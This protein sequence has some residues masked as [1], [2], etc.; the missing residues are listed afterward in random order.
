MKLL[1]AIRCF[2]FGVAT[3]A[4]VSAATPAAPNLVVFLV[5]DM[6]VMD[7][8]VPFLTDANGRPQR[9]P[10]NDYYRTPSM[11]RLAARGI[12][13]NQFCAMSVC[14]PT[15]VSILTGQNAARHRTTNWINPD[16]DNAGPLGAREW[17]WQ[18]LKP[19]DV[20]LPALLRAAGYRTIHVGKGH[21]GPRDS[22]GA[23]PRKLGFD[24][25]IAGASIGAPASYYGKQNFGHG[26]P[27]RGK[28]AVPHLEK[29]HGQDIFLTEAL[30]LE[31]K[32]QIG[33]AVKDARPFF[34]YFAHYAVHAPFESDPR[35]AA[36]YQNSGKSPQAQAFATLIEGMDKSLGDLLDHLEKLGVADNTL[37]VFL[38]DNGSD[39]PLGHEHAVACAAPLRGKKGSHYEGGMRVPFI[40]AWAKAASGNPHQQRLPIPAGAVQSQQAAVQDLFPTLLG[41]AGVRPPTGHVV[42]GLRLDTLL[43]GKPDPSRH[44][45]FLMHYP[46]SP[47][48]SEYFTTYRDGSWKVI[49]HY[50]PGPQS[51]GAAYQLFNLAEDP[52]E[53]KD[54]AATRPD[55]LRRMMQGMVASL[56]AHHAV[57]PR[58]KDKSD[59]LK[60]RLP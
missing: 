21:F 20:T 2:A 39:A 24:V 27:K 19:G 52:F 47:H 37:I 53:Q 55:D 5:D 45:R 31:A 46:H 26:H 57:Y 59:V 3:L 22:A 56:E 48:R 1:S 58:T 15:R 41:V 6:G 12:R 54:L 50:H 51:G 10:L 60:P 11:E 4:A 13:F 38:G 33:S 16:T 29:Y 8:S 9:Y 17:N 25:N 23:E 14:S 34:L 49:Y 40:A 28:A 35:F 18:G 7:T 42:D 30:T 44:Q 32:A 43:S 36:H